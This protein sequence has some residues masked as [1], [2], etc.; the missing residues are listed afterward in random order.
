MSL[1]RANVEAQLIAR[2]G[3]LLSLCNLDGTTKDGTN[4]ALNDPIRVAIRYD[5][6]DISDPVNV[7]DADLEVFTGWQIERL[8]DVAELRICETLWGNWPLYT[9]SISLEKKQLSDIRDG[10]R[11]R[12]IQLTKKLAEPYGPNVGA[13]AVGVMAVGHRIPMDPTRGVNYPPGNW[14]NWYGWSG[15]YGAW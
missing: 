4:A 15:S 6:Y 11:E 9:V 1:T 10:I 7:V 3:P 5:D 14:G 8:L 12:I 2:Q 13:G